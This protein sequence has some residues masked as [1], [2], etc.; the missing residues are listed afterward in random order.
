M[1][2]DEKEPSGH[3]RPEFETTRTCELLSLLAD[4]SEAEDSRTPSNCQIL[5]SAPEETKE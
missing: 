4:D 3:W 5:E 1:D 2:A